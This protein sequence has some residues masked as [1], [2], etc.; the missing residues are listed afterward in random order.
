MV[1]TYA[2]SNNQDS[3]HV[4]IM[5]EPMKDGK[6]N[7]VVKI[8][9]KMGDIVAERVFKDGIEKMPEK[10]KEKKKSES[11]KKK[12][13]SK[14]DKKKESKATKTSSKSDKKS[15]DK[16]TTDSKDKKSK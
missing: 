9:N 3:G 2:I 13:A 1:K 6:L 5:E 8:Y 16:K 15:A 11:K 12:S 14:T 10:K 4:V 7:G